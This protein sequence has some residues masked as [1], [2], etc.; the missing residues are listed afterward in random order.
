[1]VT[2]KEIADR[3]GVSLSVVS[4]ALN[5]SGYV[6][7]E[8]K[9]AILQAA[10]ELGY[11]REPEALKRIR[12]STRLVTLYTTNT[13]N[14]FYVEFYL[15]VRDILA[16]KGYA[17]MI[18]P[19]PDGEFPKRDEADALIFANE[20]IAYHYLS[21]AGKNDFRPAVSASFGGSRQLPRHMVTVTFDMW[22]CADAVMTFLRKLGHRRIA[23]VSPFPSSDQDARIRAWIADARE[24]LGSAAMDYYIEVSEEDRIAYAK[25]SLVGGGRNLS[26][27]TA[28]DFFENGFLAAQQFLDSG[29]DATAVIC[30]N[31]EMG[32]GFCKALRRLGVRIPDDLSVVAYDGTYLR[33]YMDQMLTVL[34]L[35]PY[36][37]GQCCA[38][39]VSDL[40]SGKKVRNRTFSRA[41]ILEGETTAPPR[42]G[43]HQ[44]DR[45]A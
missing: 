9:N 21:T 34:S 15:G 2:R 22:T 43:T 27:L 39:A 20:S 40:L 44:K 11:S 13:R 1:M 36:V 19:V 10:A 24:T 3:L 17:L 37:M 45:M 25:N 5:N 26:G 23:M 4:R 28:E 16:R 29:C 18:C 33:R 35:Q 38:E 30:F 32:V 14:P 31:E 12:R 41:E 42:N 6:A 8:K 7:P